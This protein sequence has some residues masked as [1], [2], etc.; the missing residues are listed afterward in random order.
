MAHGA[1]CP[2]Q[3]RTTEQ[4]LLEATLFGLPMLNVDMPGD[5]FP[6]PSDE[7]IVTETFP[8]EGNEFGLEFA[9][10]ISWPTP[11]DQ[12]AIDL[13]NIDTGEG[14]TATWLAV[15]DDGVVT[16]PYEP[17]LPRHVE[18]VTVPG[19]VAMNEGILIEDWPSE[20]PLRSVRITAKSFDSR[21]NVEKLVRINVAAASSIRLRS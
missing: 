4:V 14:V 11:S 7:S 9:D 21:T 10:K 8:V 19:K 13:V 12:H 2:P 3:A 17:V 6:P 15:E 18:N 5:P 1:T 20:R 16:N